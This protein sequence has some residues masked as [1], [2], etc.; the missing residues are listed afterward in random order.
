MPSIDSQEKLLR[1]S[2]PWSYRK[3]IK[4]RLNASYSDS[5]IEKVIK[6]ERQ[7]RDI[8]MVAFDLAKEKDEEDMMFQNEIL[9]LKK[10]YDHEN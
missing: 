1:S 7:N 9:T 5:Y 10:R 2:L 6:G 4:K 8:L 3:L